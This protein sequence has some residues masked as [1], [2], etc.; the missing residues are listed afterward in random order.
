M[1]IAL[2]FGGKYFLITD[3]LKKI[4]RECDFAEFNKLCECVGEPLISSEVELPAVL[5]AELD[6]SVTPV[7]MHKLGDWRIDYYDSEGFKQES[8]TV[9]QK[10]GTWLNDWASEHCKR[11]MHYARFEITLLKEW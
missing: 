10:W 1:S 11:N 9:Y 4:I 8:S 2:E 3:N 6:K 5:V 7:N